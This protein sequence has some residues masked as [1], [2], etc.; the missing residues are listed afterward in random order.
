MHLTRIEINSRRRASRELLASPYRMHGAVSCC[1]PRSTDSGRS[2]WRVDERENGTFLYVLSR[3]RPDPTIILENYGW[4]HIESSWQSRDY[5]P[6]ID[7]IRDGRSFRFRLRANPVRSIKTPAGALGE[8]AA[9]SETTRRSRGKRVG[10]LTV[11]QQRTWFLDR[12]Q[13]WGFFAGGAE[14]PSA[15]V[16]EK[17]VWTFPKKGQTVT[18]STAVFEGALEVT[19]QD[20]L[21][22]RLLEGFG[23]AKAYGC[24]LM[25]LAP[26]RVP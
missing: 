20:R 1:F 25:T 26:V 10:H 24:G 16:V 9:D 8:G 23:P 13:G 7:A 17:K 6:V 5:E 18:L 3:D 14:R 2:L 4:P 15:D 12:A 11:A 22:R 21:R 19:D